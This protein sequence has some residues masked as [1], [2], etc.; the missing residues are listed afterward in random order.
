LTACPL[1]YSAEEFQAGL[2]AIN[3]LLDPPLSSEQIEALRQALDRNGDG[4][5]DY[6]EFLE[7][8]QIVDVSQDGGDA[9]RRRQPS[10]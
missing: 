7:G 8:F 9:Q 3:A 2:R 5:V 1:A 10:L 6:K 4:S